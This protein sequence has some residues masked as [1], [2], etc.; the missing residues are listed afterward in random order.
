MSIDLKLEKICDHKIVREP[1]FLESDYRTLKIPRTLASS[2]VTFWINDYQ[3][4][5]DNKHFGWS[6][7]NDT[8]LT[9]SKRFKIYFN[10]KRKSNDDLFFL[11]YAVP[12]EQCPKCRGLRVYNDI[13]YGNLGRPKTVEKEEKLIQEVKKGVY[14]VLGSNLFHTWIGTRIKQL[15]GSKITNIEL[16]RGRIA[17]EISTYLTKYIDIQVKQSQYQ[18][19]TNEEAFFNLLS[20]EVTPQYDYDISLWYVNITFS[21][22]TGKEYSQQEELKI[23]GPVNF[24]Y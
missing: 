9:L 15:I 13:T 10:H 1:L 7:Q 16:L 6:I 11:T 2:K 23:P 22:K 24:L 14:T 19:V 3:I 18:T 17:Q 20:L 21:N 5:A 8:S 4:D 12:P